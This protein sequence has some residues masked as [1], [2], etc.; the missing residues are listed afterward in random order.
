[1]N[2][3]V[4]VTLGVVGLIAMAL[5]AIFL[6]SSSEEKEIQKLL[7]GGLEAAVAGNE[8]AVIALIS[9]NYKNG[10]QT[11]EQILHRIRWAVSQRISPAKMDGAAIQV[12]GEDADASVRV[13][14]GALKYTREFALRLHL[15][16]ESGAWKITSAEE[17]GR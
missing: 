3:Y 6:F 1:M 7:E 12:D 16:K 10:D 4:K 17:L 2:F 14:V 11:R 8:E 5:G 9:P 15:K 13:V